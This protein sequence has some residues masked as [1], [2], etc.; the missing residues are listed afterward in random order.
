MTALMHPATTPED[1]PY[2]GLAGVGLAYVLATRVAELDRV[3]AIQVARDLF[4]IGTV[5]DMAPLTGANR[6]WLLEGLSSLHRSQCKGMASPAATGR[7]WRSPSHARRH[8]FPAGA[9][10]QCRRPP[11]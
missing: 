3:E 9:T 2:R 7:S 6:I 4:C 8:R 1:S 5:A 11:W 10:H